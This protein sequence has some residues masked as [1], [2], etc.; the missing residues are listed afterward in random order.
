MVEPVGAVPTS[1]S[2]VWGRL[3]VPPC[4][5][6]TGAVGEVNI[7]GKVGHKELRVYL[8]NCKKGK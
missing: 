8:D 1:H 5:S 2:C 3:T 4:T 7:S 6:Q